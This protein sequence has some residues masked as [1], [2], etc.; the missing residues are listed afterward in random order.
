MI[1]GCS[2]YLM[3]YFHSKNAIHRSEI[4][5]RIPI[6]SVV[7]ENHIS[8]MHTLIFKAVHIHYPSLNTQND[9]IHII[10]IKKSIEKL[11]L[12]LHYNL[13]FFV[14]RRKSVRFYEEHF[15]QQ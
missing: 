2:E 8:N 9:K 15:F 3:S 4:F 10:F 1:I 7:Q 13:H 12:K 11:Q 14:F 5:I 6:Y